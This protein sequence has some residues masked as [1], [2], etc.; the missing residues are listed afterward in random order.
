MKL[1]NVD[2]LVWR[3]GY[4]PNPWEWSDWRWANGP[5]GRFEGRWDSLDANYR[6][7]Y[8]SEDLF[9]CFVE[10]LAKFRP[11]PALA[12]ELA[13]IATDDDEP[14]IAPGCWTSVIGA[15][16]ESSAR[17]HYVAPSAR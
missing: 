16:T 8:C 14:W 9:A 2:R 1:E 4:P 11:D 12:T 10:L 3:I 17:P 13:Q 6:I 15:R 7:V 5:A